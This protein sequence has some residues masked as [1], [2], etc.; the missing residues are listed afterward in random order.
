MQRFQAR[1]TEAAANIAFFNLCASA[2]ANPTRLSLYDGAGWWGGG[3]A[4]GGSEGDRAGGGEEREEG[5]A[6]WGGVAAGMTG[7]TLERLAVAMRLRSPTHRVM[8]GT[9]SRQ[10]EDARDHGAEEDSGE[11]HRVFSGP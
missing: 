3:G 10:A 5:G 1:L 6:V 7:Q 8:R 2:A 9:G 4:G 11:G